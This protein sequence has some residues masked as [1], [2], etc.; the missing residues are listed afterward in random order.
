[1]P[2]RVVLI[3]ALGPEPTVVHRMADAPPDANDA[4]VVDGNVDTTADRANAAR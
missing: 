1:M 2:V 3:Q 4:A